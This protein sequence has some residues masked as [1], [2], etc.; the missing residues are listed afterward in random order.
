[1]SLVIN[2]MTFIG[3]IDSNILRSYFPPLNN[4]KDGAKGIAPN[5]THPYIIHFV[6]LKNYMIY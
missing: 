6:N 5:G 1:M 2:L 4:A 3:R